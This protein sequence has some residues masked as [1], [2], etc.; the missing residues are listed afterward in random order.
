MTES[1]AYA[2]RWILESLLFAEIKRGSSLEQAMATIGAHMAL[3]RGEV[4]A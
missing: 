3:L 1:Q 2:I 4:T